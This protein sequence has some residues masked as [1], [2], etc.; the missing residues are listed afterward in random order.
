MK[1]C[2]GPK[3]SIPPG[4]QPTFAAKE[5]ESCGEQ[6]HRHAP[7]RQQTCKR[8]YQK[9]A[10]RSHSLREGRKNS[11]PQAEERKTEQS[12]PP[13]AH[14]ETDTTGSDTEDT[15]CCSTRTKSQEK[16]NLQTTRALIRKE[17][18]PKFCPNRTQRVE[19]ERKEEQKRTATHK[20]RRTKLPR[21]KRSPQPSKRRTEDR[22][23]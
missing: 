18:T 23:P 22:R 9:V 8:H 5:K 17:E 10:T 15:R 20:D 7:V 11:N 21:A 12:L 1:T 2:K 3:G 16:D 13:R 4:P 6:E 19:D 14:R